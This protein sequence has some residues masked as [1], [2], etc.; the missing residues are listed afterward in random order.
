[1][2]GGDYHVVN[3]DPGAVGQP[4]L[5]APVAPGHEIDRRGPMVNDVHIRRGA[6]QERVVEPLEVLAHQAA[7]QEVMGLDRI[8]RRID[9]TPVADPPVAPLDHPVVQAEPVR[10]LI[11]LG[12]EGIQ[13]EL[14]AGVVEEQVVRLS[15]VVDA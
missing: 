8:A 2:P 3:D 1:V 9:R 15:C 11:R 4:Y 7:R 5:L 14:P 10:G 12:L 6:V 13:R